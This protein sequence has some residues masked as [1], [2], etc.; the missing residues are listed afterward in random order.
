MCMYVYVM[1][2]DFITPPH[3]HELTLACSGEA[4]WLAHV[5]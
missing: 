2:S 3:L 5:S 4:S 1:S